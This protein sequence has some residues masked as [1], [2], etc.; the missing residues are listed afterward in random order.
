[1]KNYHLPHRKENKAHI[2]LCSPRERLFD[3]LS[4]LNFFNKKYFIKFLKNK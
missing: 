3:Q 1:M 2:V 4:P